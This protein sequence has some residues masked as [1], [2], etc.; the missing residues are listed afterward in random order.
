M[1]AGTVQV[2]SGWYGIYTVSGITST[3][4]F[5]VQAPVTPGGTT[6]TAGTV[7]T[8]YIAVSSMSW[9]SSI[10][11]VNT[12]FA[13]GFLPTDVVVIQDALFTAG[14]VLL[15]N[16]NGKETILTVPTPTSFTISMAVSPGTTNTASTGTIRPVN[17]INLRYA[18]DSGAYKSLRM[19]IYDCS[20]ASTGNGI[21]TCPDTSNVAVG[22]WVYGNNIAAG[23]AKV[24]AVSTNVSFTLGRNN[25]TVAGGSST[26]ISNFTCYA[27]LAP[28]EILPASS[29]GYVL[30]V[31]ATNAIKNS[32][33]QITNLT[34]F[35]ASTRASQ[36]TQYTLDL[37]PITLNNVVVGSRYR[38][39]NVTTGYTYI[40]D[41]TAASS[42]VTGNF[43]VT[44]GDT[45]RVRVR[46]GSVAPKYVNFETLA[47]IASSGASIYV[48]QVLDL[49]VA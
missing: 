29:T 6:P 23:G 18:I 40:T 45:I 46:T 14:T 30:K 3:T 19:P 10:L 48:S 42:T 26:T 4:I 27:T 31:K 47:V 34:L 25:V 7:T 17:N 9:A 35:A 32:V 15:G 39:D 20:T 28:G 33:A 12:T 41:G 43:S 8:P 24:T 16:C 49:I 22:D 2:S 44:V 38:I 36:S 37:Y 5:R 13:H 21:V 11:T 1:V